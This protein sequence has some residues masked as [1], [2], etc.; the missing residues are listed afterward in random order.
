V[1][2]SRRRQTTAS[3]RVGL[4]EALVVQH[5][6]SAFLARVKGT[7]MTGA[8]IEEGNTLAIDRL[9]GPQHGNV[10]VAVVDREFTVKR[11]HRLRRRDPS[12]YFS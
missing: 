2:A 11:L 1:S 6:E 3:K 5:P 9:P 12:G 10:V 4:N 8:S 7:L